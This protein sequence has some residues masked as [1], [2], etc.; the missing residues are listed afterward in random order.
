MRA[1]KL[2]R[3]ISIL[4][5]FNF[6]AEDGE[7]IPVWV[8]LPVGTDQNP[9][10]RDAGLR[11]LSADERFTGAQVVS[12]EQVEFRLRWSEDVRELSPLDR[13]VYPAL[14]ANEVAGSPPQADLEGVI[15]DRRQ[16]DIL[17]VVEVG[18]QDALLV[19]AV[20]RIDEVT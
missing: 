1:A 9:Y 3:K 6:Q 5:A 20:R 19:T 2:D 14:E 18:K 12:L 10:R 7:P 8:P 13:I 4:R 17:G 16:Y 15:R 11:P